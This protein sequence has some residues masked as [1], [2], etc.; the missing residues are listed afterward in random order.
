MSLRVLKDGCQTLVLL[1]TFPHINWFTSYEDVNGSS[2]FMGN[3][4]T[5]QTVGLGNI[6]IKMYDN[7]VRTLTS[8]RHVPELKKNLISLGVL[9]SDAY[10][11]TSQNGVLKV[12]KGA[13]VVMKEEKVRNIY[14]L[15]GSTQVIEVAIVSKKEEEG[16]HLW[17]QRLGHM[18]ET[19]IHE[20]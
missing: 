18:S 16:T 8:V 12:S 10:K 5:C 17:H 7:T 3:N 1:I 19:C 6:K 9:D 4:V 13:L 15:K 20:T 2:M 11:C 14:R